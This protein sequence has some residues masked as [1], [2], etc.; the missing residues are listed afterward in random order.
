MSEKVQSQ[1]SLLTPDQLFEAM[2]DSE[3]SE[4]QEKTINMA[5]DS[6]NIIDTSNPQKKDDDCKLFAGGLAQEATKKDITSKVVS[7]KRKT[8]KIQDVQKR[9]SDAICNGNLKHV[10]FF[11]K[12]VTRVAKINAPDETG[13]SPLYIGAKHGRFEIVEYLHQNGADINAQL[14]YDR[15]DIFAGWTPLHC[16]AYHGHLE[17]VKYLVQ[18]GALL[19]PGDK[20]DRTPLY[21]AIFYCKD[22]VVKFLKNAGAKEMAKIAPNYSYERL[23]D[24]ICEGDLNSVELCLKN[25]VR[26]NA[27]DKDGRSPLYIAAKL[28]RFEIVKFLL[29]EGADIHAKSKSGQSVLYIGAYSGNVEIVKLFHQ[30]GVDIN[31]KDKKGWSPLH[32]A[33]YH[34]HLDIV[35]YFFEN[36][37][38]LNAKDNKGWSPLDYAISYCK[39]DTAKYL[40]TASEKQEA[41]KRKNPSPKCSKEEI[42]SKKQEALMRRNWLQKRRRTH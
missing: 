38:W 15:K 17:V 19:N 9:L 22:D 23:F 26:V 5:E 10:E 35:K 36:G 32:C 20:K 11:L 24:A 28:G 37:A 16:A 1:S 7:V 27:N 3:I 31:A 6:T 30:K 41:L 29:Q 25:G 42:E 8:C 40:K 4:N 18:N 34:G 33:A 21:Y 39:D 13:Q 14:N 12:H 2:H